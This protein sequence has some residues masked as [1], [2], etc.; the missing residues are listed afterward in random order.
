MRVS[1]YDVWNS[2][3][4][5]KSFPVK[6]LG[7]VVHTNVEHDHESFHSYET[8]WSSSNTQDTKQ[9]VFGTI[10]QKQIYQFI[11]TDYFYQIFVELKRPKKYIATLLQT[12]FS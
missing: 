5:L 9:N 8:H 6:V 7:Q 11:E 1:V 4:V 12:I 2:G 3:T 10:F